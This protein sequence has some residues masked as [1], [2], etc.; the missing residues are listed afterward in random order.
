MAQGNVF[1]LV[2]ECILDWS[3]S[4]DSSTAG[5]SDEK[6]FLLM[7]DSGPE[8]LLSANTSGVSTQMDV[9]LKKTSGRK[10]VPSGR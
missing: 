5:Q 2:P 4:A 9:S 6:T 8:L 1:E 7:I 3:R 10:G